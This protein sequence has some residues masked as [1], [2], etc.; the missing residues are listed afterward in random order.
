MLR[1]ASY[2][3]LMIPSRGH[4]ESDR[5]KC[6]SKSE[7]MSCGEFMW[8]TIVIPHVKIFAANEVA[9]NVRK[10]KAVGVLDVLKC[11]LPFTCLPIVTVWN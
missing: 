5:K 2:C 1:F 11:L 6:V 9:V 10:K 3:A 4:G 8:G 7:I